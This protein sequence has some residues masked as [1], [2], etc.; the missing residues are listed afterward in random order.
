MTRVRVHNLSMS[1]DGYAAGPGQDLEHPVGVGGGL[2]HDWI[3]ATRY[4][5]TMIGAE[6]GSDGI[7]DAM[8]RRGDEGVG[9]TI[10]GRHMFGPV[11]G[12]WG[13]EDWNGWWGD[14]PPY[15]HPVFV[16]THHRR[17]PVEMAGG[18]TFHFVDGGI[19]SALAQARSA[20]GGLDVR[21]GGGPGTV[22]QF[23]HADLLDLLHVVVVPVLLGGGARLF[24]QDESDVAGWRLDEFVASDVVSHT[25]FVR[26]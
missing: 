9:A 5:R 17:E 24:E 3:F 1:L 8:L 18:T 4:G 21:V 11:R 6:G 20:A 19:E 23:L 22:R 2:L 26:D 10:M 14:E 15:H 12:S 7:D 25:T 16:L 13:D